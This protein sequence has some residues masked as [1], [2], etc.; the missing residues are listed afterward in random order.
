MAQQIETWYTQ[1][2]KKPVKVNYLDGNVF[3]QDNQGNIIGVEVFDGDT[4]ASLSGSV[5]ASII[6]ADGSTVSASGG[7]LGNKVSVALPSAAYAVP[8]VISIVLKLTAGSVIVTLLAVVAVV[9]ASSTDTVVDPG[10]IIPSISALIEEIEDAIA[11]IPPDY[12]ELVKSVKVCAG[13]ETLPLIFTDGYISAET[14]DIVTTSPGN[15]QISDPVLIKGGSLL[16]VPKISK[17][18][19]TVLLCECNS[20]GTPTVIWLRGTQTSYSTGDMIV[21]PVLNDTYFR[22]AGNST[23]TSYMQYYRKDFTEDFVFDADNFS[24]WMTK[25]LE[26][27]SGPI[28]DSGTAS[29]VMYEHTSSFLLAKGMT[30][31]VWSAGSSANVALSKYN[32][33][34][35][36]IISSLVH[37]AGID[38]FTYTAPDTMYVRLSARIYAPSDGFSAVCPPDYF[39]SWKIYNKELH[40]KPVAF[41][42]LYG[43]KLCAIGDSLIYG[44]RLGNG[45]TWVTAIGIKYNMDYVNLGINGNTVAVQ[46]SETSDQPMVS[47]ISSV[48]ADTDIFVLLG[49]A[50]DKRLNVP[51]GTVDSTNTSEFMGALNSIVSS[52]RT[53]CPKA[54]I[55]FM[56]TYNRYA[57]LNALGF[58]DEDYAK[59]MIEVGKRNLIPVFDNFHCSGVNFLDDNQRAWMDEANNLLK[60]VSGTVTKDDDTHHFSIEGYEFIT[61]I[62]EMVLSSAT[63][64][65]IIPQDEKNLKEFIDEL[66]DNVTTTDIISSNAYVE[67]H[68]KYATVNGV[69]YFKILFRNISDVNAGTGSTPV[70]N[71]PVP[72]GVPVFFEIGKTPFDVGSRLTYDNSVWKLYGKRTANNYTLVYGSYVPQG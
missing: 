58:G 35:E 16:Y 5:S 65:P 66:L 17:S 23:M 57:S 51:I 61:P 49:G 2:L 25:D 48:P 26:Y 55:I 13:V 36:S 19:N 56:T 60:D 38:H 31:E 70:A 68:G 28:T 52:V 7:V 37:S 8:G 29:G 43:K 9:Y 69:V 18:A 27:V 24:Q 42:S 59:A 50:N 12:S 34:S 53:R 21:V 30:I 3:S 62:Y 64:T 40:T 47:R 4:P 20:S 46:T 14:L 72:S 11:T 63:A 67:P 54:K 33:Y 10:T 22:F 45:V 6:R 15:H 41:S 71:L 32:V 44:D 39:Y 1:D